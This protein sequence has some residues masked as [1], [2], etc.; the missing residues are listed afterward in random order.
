M[1]IEMPN[2]AKGVRADSIVIGTCFLRGDEIYMRTNGSFSKGEGYYS[3]RIVRLSDGA[4]DGLE[5]DS[6]VVPIKMKCVRDC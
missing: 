6:Q 1:K 3:V 4:E 2:I 5:A